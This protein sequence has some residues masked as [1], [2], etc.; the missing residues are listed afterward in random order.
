[1]ITKNAKGQELA[2]NELVLYTQNFC[3]IGLG[4]G[5]HVLHFIL[6]Y[7]TFWYVLHIVNFKKNEVF[8]G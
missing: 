2:C 8:L 7:P 6:L 1:M 5:S 4:T 3:C